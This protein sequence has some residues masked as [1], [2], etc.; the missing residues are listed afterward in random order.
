MQEKTNAPKSSSSI[1]A[2]YQELQQ[3]NKE[4]KSKLKRAEAEREILKKATAYFARQEL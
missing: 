1:N 4:L 3:E 2:K